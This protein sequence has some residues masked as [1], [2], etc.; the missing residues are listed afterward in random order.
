MCIRDGQSGDALGPLPC[1]T[2]DA[3]PDLVQCFVHEELQHQLW[4][5]A[6]RD[7]YGRPAVRKFMSF[8]GEHYKQLN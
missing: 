5:V 1:V 4:L 8:A 2:G 6:S 7:S 3:T